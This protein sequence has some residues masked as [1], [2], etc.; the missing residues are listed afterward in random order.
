MAPDEPWPERPWQTSAGYPGHRK[1]ALVLSRST[2]RTL[3]GGCG[4]ESQ[5]INSACQ[6]RYHMIAFTLSLLPL[7]G[8][9]GVGRVVFSFSS[10]LYRACTLV[11]SLLVDT[12]ELRSLIRS[13]RYMCMRDA[14]VRVRICIRLQFFWD[15]IKTLG[16]AA[17]P[18]Y[19]L[20][21]VIGG[22]SA[23]LTLKTVKMA[24]AK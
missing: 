7:T 21:I 5:P 3:R 22:L 15:E 2:F 23:E 14:H 17:C 16:T 6:I 18:P 8:S 24:S 12:N 11:S 13:I 9:L 4:A 19:H 1:L 10:A 20:A